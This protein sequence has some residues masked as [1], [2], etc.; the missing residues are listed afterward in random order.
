[1]VSTVMRPNV[2]KLVWVETWKGWQV[3]RAPPGSGPAGPRTDLDV[4][5]L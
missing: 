4:S 1:M 2:Q 3:A 5:Y